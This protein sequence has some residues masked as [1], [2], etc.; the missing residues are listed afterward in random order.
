MKWKRL[1]SISRFAVL[2]LA[3]SFPTTYG[4]T[5]KT[6]KQVGQVAHVVAQSPA[7]LDAEAG[8]Q[9]VGVFSIDRW[10]AVR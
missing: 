6:A 10:Q 1:R 9:R 4:G 5:A 3:L 7:A 8:I 2:G